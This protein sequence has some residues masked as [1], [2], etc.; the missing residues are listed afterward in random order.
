MAQYTRLDATKC[1]CHDY[2]VG[3]IH[4]V[5]HAKN[6]LSKTYGYFYISRVP[7]ESIVLLTVS[8]YSTNDVVIYTIEISMANG[9]QKSIGPSFCLFVRQS[10]PQFVTILFHY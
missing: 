6:R 10:V 1:N 8:V 7:V 9:F 4:I 5:A 2:S 3:V